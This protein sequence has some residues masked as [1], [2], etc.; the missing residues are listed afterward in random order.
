MKIESSSN[1]ANIQI[2]NKTADRASKSLD[3]SEL[4]AAT[5]SNVQLSDYLQLHKIN[6][7]STISFNAAKVEEIKTA[8]AEGRYQVSTKAITE[9]LL[10]TARDI[11]KSQQNL[12]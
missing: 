4:N 8:I 11:L 6:S 5:H 12:K 10:T 9:S 2:S 7:D 1:N 3:S